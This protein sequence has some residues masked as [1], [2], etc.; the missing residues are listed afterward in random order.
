MHFHTSFSLPSPFFTIP[1]LRAASQSKILR[2]NYVEFPT[3]SRANHLSSFFMTLAPYKTYNTISRIYFCLFIL[4][5]ISSGL[6]FTPSTT[7]RSFFPQ[8]IKN[9]TSTPTLSQLRDHHHSTSTK[10]STHSLSIM[11]S[12]LRASTLISPPNNKR[13]RSSSE[14]PKAGIILPRFC[15]ILHRPKNSIRDYSNSPNNINSSPYKSIRICLDSP[16]GLPPDVA[17]NVN[18]IAV[19]LR[20]LD[21]NF[22]FHKMKDDEIV[23]NSAL[24]S[25]FDILSL[26][27]IQDYATDIR[28]YDYSNKS[29]T[30][31][32]MCI[33]HNEEYLGG[34]L[35]NWLRHSNHS[36]R[37]SP[38]IS[39]YA[40]TVCFFLYTNMFTINI[41][42]FEHTLRTQIFDDYEGDLQ[43]DIYERKIG[44][45]RGDT[46][47][48]WT[49]ALCMDTTSTALDYVTEKTFER[50]N[51]NKDSIF[52]KFFR[53]IEPH[54]ARLDMKIKDD[55]NVFHEQKRW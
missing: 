7:S 36:I 23:P 13:L 37:A 8:Y 25:D 20:V 18:Y 28:T 33:E 12:Q 17:I 11:S 45:S 30:K 29:T 43:L 39:L 42:S 46:L 50:I 40:P 26:E 53:H 9:D 14:V 27:T 35:F 51:N 24:P 52:K 15:E 31:F 44:I 54:P 16:I 41:P 2:R 5:L 22:T 34:Y 3:F 49:K 47:K 21:K 1:F 10:L 55:R 6:L 48:D 38:I 32:T 4:Q 19:V